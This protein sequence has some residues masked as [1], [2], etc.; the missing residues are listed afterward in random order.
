MIE[1]KYLRLR[2]G[3]VAEYRR[4]K[5]PFFY[6]NLKPKEYAYYDYKSPFLNLGMFG[7][8]IP[9]PKGTTFRYCG[10]KDKKGDHVIDKDV[11]KLL[12]IA[13][14]KVEDNILRLGC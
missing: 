1:R 2:K 14:G 11:E 7:G 8:L 13:N 10:W 6:I 12:D 5:T 4:I 3:V 9:L